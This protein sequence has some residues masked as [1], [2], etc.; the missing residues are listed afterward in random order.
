MEFCITRE[1]LEK[2]LADLK[3]CEANGFAAS[4]AVFYISSAGKGVTDCWAE[5]VDPVL[6]A[7]PTDPKQ[8]WGRGACWQDYRL[9]NGQCV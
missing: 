8:N 9:I 2:A 7:H 1:Q 6:K 3:V 5:Y 4:D